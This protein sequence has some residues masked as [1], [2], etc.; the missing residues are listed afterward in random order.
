MNRVARSRSMSRGCSHVVLVNRLKNNL[1]IQNRLGVTDEF[2]ATRA[3]RSLMTSYRRPRT[4]EQYE[5][6]TIRRAGLGTRKREVIQISC[7]RDREID[8]ASLSTDKLRFVVGSGLVGRSF[9][10]LGNVASVR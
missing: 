6:R 10:A 2:A 3:R 9:L 7:S 1:R 8:M 5:T 4:R